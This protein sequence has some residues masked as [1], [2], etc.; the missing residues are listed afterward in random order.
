[1]CAYRSAVRIS[2]KHDACED[3]TTRAG[4]APAPSST[5]GGSTRSNARRRAHDPKWDHRELELWELPPV[6]NL[7]IIVDERTPLRKFGTVSSVVDTLVII[8]SDES[9][10]QA[11]AD[12]TVIFTSARASLGQIFEIFGPVHQP[13][14]SIR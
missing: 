12:D 14:Y 10:S 3:N 9:A 2:H 13:M 4:S 7:S 8:R 11:L 5:F 6:E 1:M